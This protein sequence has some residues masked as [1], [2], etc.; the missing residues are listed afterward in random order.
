MALGTKR[1]GAWFSRLFE[2]RVNFYA[3]LNSHADTV[4]AGM[5]ALEQWI[6]S[7]TKGR[8]QVVRDLEREADELKLDL[9]RKLNEAF[10]TPFDREDIYDLSAKLDEVINAAKASVRE[11]EALELKFQGKLE[12]EMVATLVEGTR[13]LKNS[14]ENLNKDLQEAANQATL[15][16]SPKT[17]SH[18]SIALRSARSSAATISRRC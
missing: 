12:S 9:E 17:D 10:V 18:A 3:L 11:I 16:E 8:G 15:A 13:C 2:P 6:H 1:T 5:E 4:L 14:F 7:G